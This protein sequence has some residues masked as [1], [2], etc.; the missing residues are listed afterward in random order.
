MSQSIDQLKKALKTGAFSDALT[1]VDNLEQ[2]HGDSSEFLYLAAVACR[3]QKQFSR[4]T[5]YLQ[6]LLELA[7]GYA[8]ALQELGHVYRDQNQFGDATEYYRLA[9]QV[10]PALV[11]SWKGL[12]T[13]FKATG[14]STLALDAQQR[15]ERMQQLPKPLR[16][17]HDLLAE[18]KLARAEH[19]AREFLKTAPHHPDAMMILAEVGQQLGALDEAL[20]LYQAITR[21]TPQNLMA[22]FKCIQLLRKLNDYEG[23]LAH[24]E[25]LQASYPDDPQC[26][27]V[28]AIEL[29]Q[30]GRYHE[31]V[32]QFDRVIDL[33]PQDPT[34]Y[35]SKAHALKT[36]G[37]QAQAVD[38][39][40][41]ALK[42]N[43]NHGEAW[44]SLANLKTVKF[45]D[46][47]IA[48]MQTAVASTKPLSTVDQTY[49]NFALGKAFE[50]VKQ[51]E[52][53]FNH[54]NHGNQLKKSQSRYSSEQLADE[55]L[56]TKRVFSD[57]WFSNQQKAGCEAPDPIFVVGLP[58]AGSTLIE[59][60]LSSHSQIDGT[61]ELPN[62]LATVHQLRL[63]PEGYPKCLT[64]LDSS[65]YKAL[66]QAYI[67]NT[68]VHRSGAPLFVDKMPN[69]F[70]HIG[71]IK[72][73]LPNAKIIDARRNPM[74]CCFSGF[75][76]LF[77]E[78]QEFSY[79]LN[80]LG[81]YYREYVELMEFW[82]QQFPGEILQ[83]NHE[84]LI[85]D[86]E[87][88]VRRLLNYCGVAEE[89]GCYSFH[90][91]QRAVR[92]ASSEQ[93]RKPINRSGMDRWKPYE[94]WL[95]PLV[96]ELGDLPERYLKISSQSFRAE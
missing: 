63:E 10:N 68:R 70:R 90:T 56:A 1:I 51:Y 34:A 28:Y 82:H 85:D 80:D 69:N 25:E 36:L 91:T 40:R 7:P 35:V 73:M 14:Q 22:H 88:Q 23:A 58:R 74:D 26:I 59:Q 37:E 13:C 42:I 67:D 50:D 33:L 19:I 41:R 9:T 77:A 39:Y 57:D 47:D 17:A 93:V 49:L 65:R 44:Y 4:A 54:Y 12:A 96:D 6:R 3:Y 75:K 16:I 30:V 45:D 76:Q 60:I 78:G 92:T 64:T 84:D 27:S 61:L 32:E 20:T 46:D 31:A 79:S 94:P 53:S 95:T 8:R 81:A 15:A 38:A 43:P 71:L 72:L 48:Q 62:V 18:G 83:L 24:A 87:P 29:M 66:G 2:Q 86:F 5:N 55:F 52:A 21:L 89:E 11:A